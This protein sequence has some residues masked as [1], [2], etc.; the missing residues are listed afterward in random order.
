MRRGGDLEKIKCILSYD[1]TNYSGFQ[2]QPNKRTIQGEIEQALQ[3]MH[4]G[5]QIR[6][7][8]SGRTDTGVH[9]KG[10]T[11]MFTTPLQIPEE[12]WQ[13]ALNTLL[14]DDLHVHQ[15]D[16]VP[17]DFHV[18]FDAL[19]KE[20][21]YFIWNDPETD[22][23]KRNYY[24]LYPYPLNVRNMQEACQYLIGEHDFTSFSSAKA[25][26]KGSKVRKLSLVSCLQHG[27][28]I[29]VIVKGNGFL[30]HM[31]RII[32]GTLIEIGRGD[33]KPTDIPTLIAA[34]D[35]KVAGPTAPPQGLYLWNVTYDLE[36]NN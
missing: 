11:F 16:K 7:Y 19:E 8:A 36:E 4:K 20:Y 18:R 25:T 29:E 26:A 34:K 5:E 9:A 17:A 30:Y 14:P 3:R 1:G 12:N 32:V 28:E 21:R 2:I 13:K 22:V 10:Q 31:V 15:V 24:Y 33:K 23:F 6:I 35:R 27:K